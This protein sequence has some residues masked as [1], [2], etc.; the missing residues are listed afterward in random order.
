MPSNFTYC[1]LQSKLCWRKNGKL[2][3]LQTCNLATN[4]LHCTVA[5]QCFLGAFLHWPVK[6]NIFALSA[7]NPGFPIFP[8]FL[9]GFWGIN[10]SLQISLYTAPL[11]L[12]LTHP[13]SQ[14][15]YQVFSIFAPRPPSNLYRGNICWKYFSSCLWEHCV[16][17]VKVRFEP[18]W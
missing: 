12:S 15:L 4:L 13:L 5:Q 3:K 17:F 11:T 1:L 16:A 14:Y 2:S 10:G 18:I 9:C 7:K 6:R 8:V